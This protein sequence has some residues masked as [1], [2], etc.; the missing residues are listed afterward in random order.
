MSLHHRTHE[1][2]GANHP[3][4]EHSVQDDAGAPA[5]ERPSFYEQVDGAWSAVTGVAGGAL[6]GVAMI[7]AAEGLSRFRHLGVD[8]LALAGSAARHF[9]GFGGT[10]TS[11][12]LFAAFAGAL[13]GG[14][15]AWLARRATRVLPRLLFFSV[16]MPAMWLLL[17]AF[18]I[19]PLSPWMRSVPA[20]P[21]LGG[22]LV[23]GLFL[24]FSLPI[25]RKRAMPEPA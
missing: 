7:A 21:L 25:V 23:Y 5:H 6:G 15:I 16:L 14:G 12:A 24:T 19:L 9:P 2:Y 11:G 8:Y 18:V 13:V 4:W 10:P 3:L 1:A 17:Q 20:L 22:A